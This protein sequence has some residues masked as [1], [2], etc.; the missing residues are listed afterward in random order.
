MFKS[1]K[2]Q[3]DEV[4]LVKLKRGNI[5]SFE[6]IYDRYAPMVLNF[7]RKMIKD[8]MRAE[9]ITQNIFMRLYVSRNSLEPGLS[10][11]NWLFVCARNESLDVLRS[12]WAKDVA[13]VQEIMEDAQ[14]SVP[15]D[16]M[17]RRE[18]AAQLRT[19]VDDLP[20]QRAKIL[21]MSKLDELSNREIAERLGLLR[22]HSGEAS[23]TRPERSSWKV[24]LT[25]YGIG[26][27]NQKFFLS[28]Y[29]NF[30]S[31]TFLW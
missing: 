13:K 28:R 4:L 21:K 2:D 22:T 26:I 16:E 5:R 18:S 19:M 17:I 6:A 12:K 1:I 24:E 15:E 8:Q 20:D 14:V 31:R 3:T 23:G 10:L 30:P 25:F 7:V 27:K 11:K 9:D 29:V